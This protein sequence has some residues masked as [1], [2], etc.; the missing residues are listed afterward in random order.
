M[1]DYPF[2]SLFAVMIF[3]LVHLWSE[4]T[5]ILGTASHGRFLSVG[6]GV[7]IAYVFV[8]ILPKLSK[9]DALI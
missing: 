1:I 8:D 7:A 3:A 6:G 9:N 4:K 2:Q 5:H